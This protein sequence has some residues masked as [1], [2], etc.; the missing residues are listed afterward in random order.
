MAKAPAAAIR[1]ALL[2]GEVETARALYEMHQETLD[3]WPRLALGFRVAS[4]ERAY[5]RAA[6]VARL[7]VSEFPGKPESHVFLVSALFNQGQVR[8]ALTIAR[9]A[10]E[11]FPDHAQL[12]QLAAQASTEDGRTRDAIGYHERLLALGHEP[13]NQHIRIGRI[14]LKLYQA[15]PGLARFEQAI[16]AGADRTGLAASMAIAAERAG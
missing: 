1:E 8:Q 10:L 13:A 14:H 3:P 11:A 7:A 9:T 12:L 15:E 4:A 2:S 6:E 5:S 16:A